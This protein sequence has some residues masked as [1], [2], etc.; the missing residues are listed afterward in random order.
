MVVVWEFTL[1]HLDPGLLN[2]Y[3]YDQNVRFYHLPSDREEENTGAASQHFPLVSS[4]ASLTPRL[5]SRLVQLKFYPYKLYPPWTHQF[6]V[7][8]ESL[9]DFGLPLASCVIR[10]FCE[11][12]LNCNSIKMFIKHPTLLVWLSSSFIHQ[13]VKQECRWCAELLPA[14]EPFLPSS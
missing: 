9:T 2:T 11:N 14:R 13:Q 1:F 3:T 4:L 7:S 6:T 10:S 8:W 12:N 5:A